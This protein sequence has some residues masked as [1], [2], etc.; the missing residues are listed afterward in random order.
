MVLEDGRLKKCRL[1]HGGYGKW[2]AFTSVPEWSREIVL[3]DVG[4]SWIRG[5]HDRAAAALLPPPKK[6]PEPFSLKRKKK[7]TLLERYRAYEAAKP[8]RVRRWGEWP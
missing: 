4:K 6:K 5:W 7:L 8:L 2:Y 3:A 1:L